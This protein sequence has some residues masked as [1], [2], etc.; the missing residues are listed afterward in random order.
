[1][2][3]LD[4]IISTNENPERHHLERHLEELERERDSLQWQLE[5]NQTSITDTLMA[6]DDCE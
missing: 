3:G 4:T 1:M 5:R 2:N 6:I